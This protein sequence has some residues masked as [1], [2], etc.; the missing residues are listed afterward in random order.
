MTYGSKIRPRIMSYYF[1][2]IRLFASWQV[3]IDPVK[4]RNPGGS[5]I[6]VRIKYGRI[7]CPEYECH[8]RSL[9]KHIE[10]SICYVT[11]AQT[12]PY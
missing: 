8:K 1:A 4:A 10:I 2:K 7:F 11:V 6:G 12:I 5:S 3:E 9:Q